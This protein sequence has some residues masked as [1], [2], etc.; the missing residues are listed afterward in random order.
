MKK[1]PKKIIFLLAVSLLVAVF[2]WRG[3]VGKGQSQPTFQTAKIEKG[4]LVV[5]VSAS[6]RVLTTGIINIT[7]NAT[8]LVKKVYV[9]DGD[10]VAAGQNIAE[11]S[12][13][14]QG[15]QKNAQG[16]SSYLSAKNTIDSTNATAYSLRSTKDTAWKKFYDLATNSTYQNSDGTPREDLRNSSAEFQSAQGDWLAAE[17]KYNNQQ[18]VLEQ[19]KASLNNSWLSYQLTSPIITAPGSGTIG[20]VTLV[21]GMVLETSTSPQRVAVIENSSAPIFTFNLT[22]IDIPK[23]K[24]GQKATITLD[25]L[26]DKT[27]TGKVATVD[28]IGTTSNNVTS[29]PA[30]IQLDT[31]P[32]EI[33]PNMTANVSI[34]TDTKS[35]VLLIPS[36]AVVK[37]TD[38]SFARVLKN[39]QEQQIPVQIGI[40][41]DTQT[42]ITA[43]LSEGD[44]VITGTAANSSAQQRGSFSPFGGGF[45]GGQRR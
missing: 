9:A 17:A 25:S 24:A 43:G 22:E 40:S 1:I 29:Y 36:S 19:A 34:I 20:N 42:E 16:W 30:T 4:T 35:D 6:G 3:A 33:L 12:L 15:Q 45:G 44:K 27:F 11:I 23:V 31:S 2:I 38:Q 26:P 10:N 32:P 37:Q 13:D 18:A 7:T 5:S 28:R 41:S 21:E 14:L 39:G 8:G